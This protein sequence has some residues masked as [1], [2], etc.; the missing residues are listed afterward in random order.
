MTSLKFL[1]MEHNN[2]KFIDT[3]AMQ[4]LQNLRIAKF[5]Y[6]Q[7][8]LKSRKNNFPLEFGSESPF[9]T[10]QSNIEELYLAYNNIT[11]IFSDWKFATNL[12]TL[13]LSHNQLHSI[14]VSFI[15]ILII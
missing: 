10:I 5:S 6:N 3:Y 9:T 8:T 7:L 1:N 4:D 13:D 11:E 12:N 2:M 15:I 14:R